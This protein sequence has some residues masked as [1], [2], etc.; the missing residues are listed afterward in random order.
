MW[1]VWDS[2]ERRGGFLAGAWG[3]CEVCRVWWGCLVGSGVCRGE[4][5]LWGDVFGRFW[6]RLRGGLAELGEA[7]DA[8]EGGEVGVCPGP[9][10]G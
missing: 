6:W 5:N 1:V 9:S 7:A 3:C 8:G 4:R 2:R 10:G